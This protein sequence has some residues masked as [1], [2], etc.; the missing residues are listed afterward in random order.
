MIPKEIEPKCPDE[1][2]PDGPTC[3]RC[4]GPRGASGA[5]SGGFGS[6]VHISTRP[7]RVVSSLYQYG[8]LVEQRLANGVVLRARYDAYGYPRSRSPRRYPTRGEW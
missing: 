4:G 1:L 6:W 8:Q 5:G 3:P 7:D 2:L